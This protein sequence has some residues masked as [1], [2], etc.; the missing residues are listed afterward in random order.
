VNNGLDF[1]LFYYFNFWISFLFLFLYSGLG[2]KCDVIVTQVTKH[3][4]SMKPVTNVVT[5]VT[6][7]FTQSYNIE[8]IIESSGTNN[9]I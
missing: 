3:N 9:I 7:T 8:K 2:Q 4:K 1:I 5:Y 6:V